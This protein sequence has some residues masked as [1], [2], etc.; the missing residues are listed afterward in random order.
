MTS[1]CSLVIAL[2]AALSVLSLAGLA[3]GQQVSGSISGV[4]LDAQGAVVQNAKVTLLDQIQGVTA[5]GVNTSQEGTFVFTPLA[6]GIY[7]VTIEAAGFKKQSRT[8]VPLDANQCL[9]LPP[10]ALELGSSKEVVTV[11]WRGAV[12]ETISSARSGVIDRAQVDNLAMNGRSIGAVLRVLPGVENDTNSV[13]GQAIAGQRNDQYTYT[14]DGVTTQDSGCGCFAF[15]YSVDAIAEISV[16]TNALPAEFGHSAGPQITIVSKSGGRQFHGTGYW[17]HRDEGLNANSYMNNLN[18]VSRPI[19]RYLTAG[20][21][22]GG[23]FYIPHVLNK[24]RDKIFFFV[25]Q[26]WNHSLAPAALQELTMPTSLERQGVFTDARNSAGVLQVIIDPTTGAP[27]PNQTIPKNRWNSY[28]TAILNWLPQPNTSP[29]ATYNWISQVPERAPQFDQ[30]YRADYN[31]SDNWRLTF[32]GILSHSTVQDPYSALASSNLYGASTASPT[33]A[34]GVN[35]HVSTIVNPTLTNEFIYGNTRN[36]LPV[37]S[38][39][40]SSPYR[41][42]NSP[43]LAIP[44]LYPKA[45]PAGMVPNLAFGGIPSGTGRLGSTIG[46]NTAYSQWYGLPYANNNPTVNYTDNLTKVAGTHTVRAGVFIESATKTQSPYGDVDGSLIFDQDSQNP[47]D[48]DWAYANALLGNYRAFTQISN[49]EVAKYRY[50]QVEWYGQDTWK[51]RSNLTLN[52]GIRFSNMGRLHEEN[53]LVSSFVPTAFNPQQVVVLYRP[54]CVGPSPCGGSSR[55]AV[56]PLT[57]AT[58][59]GG[60][61]GAEVPGVGNINNGM[62]RQGADGEPQG[63]T[64]SRGPQFG[65]RFGLAWT[66]AGSG[67]KTV[68]RMGGGVFYERIQ[69]NYLYYQ[70]TNPPVLR[71]SQLWYGNIDNIAS[72]QATNFP[73]YAGGVAGDGHVPTVYNY[74]LGV[75]R[76]LPLNLLLDVAYAGSLSRHQTE[77]VPFND[78]AFG[79]AWLP[80]NQDPTKC[81]SIAG[82]NLNGDNALPVSFYRPYIGYN[83]PAG[84]GQGVLY[85]FGGTANYNSLQ[86]SLNRRLSRRL[87]MDAAYTWSKAL[88]VQS[89]TTT[90]GI[91]PPGDDWRKGMYGPL[92]FDRTQMLTVNYLLN[93]PDFA[94]RFGYLNNAAGRGLLDGWQLSGIT[95]ISSG[96]PIS[97]SSG[98]SSLYSVSTG[99]ATISGAQLNREITGSEDVPARY[100]FT[101]NPYSGGGNSQAFFD[102]SCFAPAPRGSVGMDSGWNR[103]RGPGYNNWDVSV[104]KKFG[105][106]KDE[107]RYLQLRLEAFNMPNH[108]E[109]GGV[110]LNATFNA[111][112]GITNLPAAL[113]GSGGRFGFGALNSVRSNSQRILQIAAKLYF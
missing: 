34:W 92:D 88:G 83:G 21:N 54:G 102:A 104:F 36:Y 87:Q 44:L 46:S 25:Q 57:G 99:T 67:G 112:G 19:Y 20:W 94:R 18:G 98:N 8:D 17:F 2:R 49:Y 76:T 55:V 110:N 103:L 13:F 15:R 30:V 58:L 7:T 3:H 74:N 101:C 16:V 33:G 9:G 75:Q 85:E 79:S 1:D 96:A 47:G 24:N 64:K 42:A 27:F 5:M 11:D 6:P 107:S 82:C 43:G 78:A 69:G 84:S 48:T 93:L 14:L 91:L 108:T 52:F 90:N 56:N 109:W 26:E 59:A 113:G 61:I 31:L 37:D 66:P 95:A 51:V 68:I 4:V 70:T 105:L 10:I 62:V 32:R 86:V 60:F 81:P 35:A 39:G 40:N 72:S 41:R 73:V 50:N 22:L 63:L 38:P 71:E 111:A 12:L 23:P 89:S 65:P 100:V 28:G 45:D 53:N 80:Q 29:T 77:L 97:S 106:G